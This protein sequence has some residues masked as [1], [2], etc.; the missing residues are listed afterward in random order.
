[1]THNSKPDQVQTYR[2]KLNWPHMH[3][4]KLRQAGDEITVSA[5]VRDFLIERKR[6]D[7]V[8]AAG[9]ETAPHDPNPGE[10]RPPEPPAPLKEGAK[11]DEGAKKEKKR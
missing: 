1:M 4:G 9:A 7:V 3:K 10:G 5:T 2:F 8:S 11:P 6:G